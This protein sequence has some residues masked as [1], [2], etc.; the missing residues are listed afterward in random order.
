MRH[1]EK[2]V[3]QWPSAWDSSI[4]PRML[5]GPNG[6]ANYAGSSGRGGHGSSSS[7]RLEPF[8]TM[9]LHIHSTHSHTGRKGYTSQQRHGWLLVPVVATEAA[10]EAHVPGLQDSM[11]DTTL[12]G[13][14]V[15]DGRRKQANGDKRAARK[16]KFNA[17]MKELRPLRMNQSS[18]KGHNARGSKDAG[19][20][21][22]G[23]VRNPSASRGLRGLDHVVNSLH[24]LS[25]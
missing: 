6:S 19:G 2:L 11:R 7:S 20:K 24:A 22:R 1:I 23:P 8:G 21:G 12:P 16:R 3:T 4:K 10:V 5:R 15:G 14:D 13:H 25:A 9:E 17:D 18:S